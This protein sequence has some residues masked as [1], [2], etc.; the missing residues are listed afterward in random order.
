MKMKTRVLIIGIIIILA[1]S[2]TVVFSQQTEMECLRLYKD[3][4][5]LA[6][7]PEMSLAERQ[8]IE[9]HKSLVFEYVE[10][11]CPDFS[12]LEFM[13]NNYNQNSL[14]VKSEPETKN[15]ECIPTDYEKT[16]KCLAIYHCSIDENP[17]LNE[18]CIEI[19]KDISVREMCS[20]PDNVIIQKTN[21]CMVLPLV[22]SKHCGSNFACEFDE[23]EN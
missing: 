2:L 9:L 21:G 15:R 22:G 4:R 16:R 5:E 11:N 17:A 23:N 10:K 18:E 12:D 20:N 14:E 8:T 13:Y 1:G 19:D 7:T 3:I 6:G